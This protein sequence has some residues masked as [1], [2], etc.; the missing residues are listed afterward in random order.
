[1]KQKKVFYKI[2]IVVAVAFTFIT[3]TSLA[4]TNLGVAEPSH[5]NTSDAMKITS[6]EPIT[7]ER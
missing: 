1:M 7:N 5:Q 2:I 6:T 4:S 3:P